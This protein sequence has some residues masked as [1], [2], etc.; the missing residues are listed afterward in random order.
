MI[1]IG[2]RKGRGGG[3]GEYGRGRRWEEIDRI[4]V[5]WRKEEVARRILEC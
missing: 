2:K 5:R 3:G 4:W 1:R